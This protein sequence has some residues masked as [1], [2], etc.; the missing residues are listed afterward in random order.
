M[1]TPAP[2]DPNLSP[3]ERIDQVCTAFE[4]AWKAGEAPRLE[5]W[6][7]GVPEADRPA[8]RH[9]LLLLDVHYRRRR[10]DPLEAAKHR[11]RSPERALAGLP[12]VTDPAPRMAGPSTVAPLENAATAPD[13]PAPGT[14][15]FAGDYELAEEIGRGGMGVVYHGRDRG[16]RRTLAVKVLLERHGHSEELKRRF[17]EEAQIMG[18]LQHPGIVPVY[19]LGQCADRRPFFSMKQIQGQTLAEMLKERAPNVGRQPP[20]DATGQG[21]D[22][23]RSPED[24]PRFLA[25]FEQVCQTLAFAHARGVIHR[26]LK[27]PNIMVGAFGEVQ[28]MD[29]GLAKVLKNEEMRRSG[30]EEMRRSG[31]EETDQNAFSPH[32]LIPSSPHLCATQAGTILGTP[33]Y[34]APEQARGEID[35]LDERCDVFGLGA[36]LCQILTGKPPFVQEDSRERLRRGAAGDLADAFARLDR[37]GADAELIELARSCL[38]PQPT[39]RP[40]HAGVVADA[41]DRHRAE[42]QERLRR[43]E[44]ERAEARV[45][46]AEERKRREVERQKRRATHFAAVAGLL[47]VAGAAGVGLW[48][49]H[50]QAERAAA[51]AETEYK[52]QQAGQEARLT[53]KAARDLRG[54]LHR[55]LRQAGG[56][57]ELLNKPAEWLGQLQ[58]AKAALKQAV[59]LVQT[60]GELPDGSLNREIAELDRLLQLDERDYQLAVALEKISMDKASFVVQLTFD[61]SGIL[62]SYRKAF[63]R[64]GLPAPVE[65]SAALA[66]RI[67][68]SPIRVLLLA[69]LDDWAFA[70]SHR[71]DR[72]ELARRLL[73]VAGRVDADPWRSQLPDVSLWWKHP[74]AVE[75]KL[76]AWARSIL[77]QPGQRRSRQMWLLIGTMLPGRTG[78]QWLRRGQA[79][80]PADFWLNLQLGYALLRSKPAE[81]AGFY[82]AALA[83][84]PNAAVA[85]NSLGSALYRQKD[86][87]GAVE[88]YTRALKLAPRYPL[89]LVN[90]GEIL[91]EKGNLEGAFACIQEAVRSDPRYADAHCVLGM[92][93]HAKKDLAAALREYDLAIKLNPADARFYIRRGHTLATKGNQEGAIQEYRRAIALDPSLP[94]AY[95]KLGLALLDQGALP[96]PLVQ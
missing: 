73:A 13:E 58:E 41:M 49:Q 92:V 45:Q 9:E 51:R 17:L 48:Y 79:E 40:R 64:A 89:A 7:Q 71:D 50:D 87:E 3:A 1:T 82:R 90:L 77:A 63:A 14:V 31:D 52:Q 18:Q 12:D 62:T 76:G 93:W 96:V 34:M 53:L 57:F 27:P 83:L 29:W 75:Q 11:R 81:A 56:V 21:V 66:E 80:Y 61:W 65:D 6:L 60:A 94:G 5:D 44:L 43:A 33:A 47:L 85:Y 39:D 16:L 67:Q 69:A 38:A 54:Q 26:D 20:E 35:S 55:K 88:Y 2:E 28:V 95:H 78:E 74:K 72:L 24:L 25:I 22:T 32:P 36:I 4:A 30:D 19:E 42:V 91:R 8:L 70:A 10:G 46:A 23:P 37:C 68:Q 84:R 86:L 59:A 15:R